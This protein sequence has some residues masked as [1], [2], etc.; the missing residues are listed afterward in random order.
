MDLNKV[1]LV[2][3][4]TKDP[5]LKTTTSGQTVTSFGLATNR[6]WTDKNGQK[7]EQVEF[8]NLVLWGRTAEIAAQFSKKGAMLLIE[9]RLQ[10]RTWTDRNSQERRTTEIMVERLQLGPR[11]AGTAAAPAKPADTRPALGKRSLAGT[12]PLDQPADEIPVI[13]LED[14]G[15]IRPEDIPF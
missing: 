12:P 2:G 11:A 15:E 14:E 9:G 5:E 13:N 1:I 4:V 8:H 10:T 6:T 3:R 7:Q